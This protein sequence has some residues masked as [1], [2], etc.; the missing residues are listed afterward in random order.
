MLILLG[1]TQHFVPSRIRFFRFNMKVQ[2]LFPTW[3]N[4]CHKLKK[5]CNAKETSPSLNGPLWL[6]PLNAGIQKN[7]NFNE[8]VSLNWAALYSCISPMLCSEFPNKNDWT[9]ITWAQVQ[10][11]EV[12]FKLIQP[13]GSWRALKCSSRTCYLRTD[14][15]SIH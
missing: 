4:N 2:Y 8:Y 1:K 12:F 13:C 11:E 3:S 15:R 7:K 9:E 14:A 6:V 10:N 5:L